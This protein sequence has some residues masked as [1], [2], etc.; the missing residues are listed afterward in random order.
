MARRE[1]LYRGP[2]QIDEEPPLD[3]EIWS[4]SDTAVIFARATNRVVVTVQEV[5]RS[6]DDERRLRLDGAGHTI[7]ALDPENV[8]GSWVGVPVRWPTGET[9]ETSTVT[10]T[11]HG[12]RVTAPGHEPRGLP[13][14]RTNV[15]GSTRWI[16]H[17]DLRIEV[18]PLGRTGCVPCGGR[19]R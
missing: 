18:D 13:G 19:R 5:T 4:T 1:L 3:G 12:V 15:A 10:W 17:G 2:L 16:Q 6:L 8:L 11:N 7:Q 9:W 14:A